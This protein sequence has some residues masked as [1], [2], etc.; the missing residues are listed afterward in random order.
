MMR[1]LVSI[2][3]GVLMLCGSAY[4]Q[5]YNPATSVLSNNPPVVTSV[6]ANDLTPIV[7]GGSAQPG[8]SFINTNQLANYALTQAGAISG[9]ALIGGDF[10]TNLF[11]RGASVVFTGSATVAYSA[12][13]RWFV[14]SGTNTGLTTASYTS[15]VPHNP[16]S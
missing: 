12:A 6:G 7:P 13:D 9:N 2:V 1:Y 8:Q 5:F 4:A 16:I 10:G 11:Q 14:W 15:S 3:A